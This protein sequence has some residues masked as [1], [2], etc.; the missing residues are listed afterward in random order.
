MTP[1]VVEP[2]QS[3]LDSWLLLA[4]DAGGTSTRATLARAGVD[5]LL[6]PIGFGAAGPGNPLTA[7][8]DQAVE[9]IETAIAEAR[10]AADCQQ[11][12][13]VALL[14]VAGAASGLTHQRLLDWGSQ[15]R[16]AARVTV[17]AD[18]APV[19]AAADPGP[20][21]GIISGT[22]SVVIAR[23]RAGQPSV[24]GGW[25]YLLG[26]EGSG[27]S[28]GREAVRTVLTVGE[29]GGATTQLADALLAHF[30]SPNAALLP[31]LIH[32]LPHP[33]TDLASLARVVV[34]LAGEGDPC[35]DM[36]IA[37]AARDLAEVAARAAKRAGLFGEE[38][39]LALSGGVLTHC[40]TLRERL[41][42]ELIRQ[43]IEVRNA[44]V[45]HDATL[46]GL[47]MAAADHDPRMAWRI[48]PTVSK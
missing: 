43:G 25:G 16:L 14:A 1:V 28:I 36:L 2:D 44:T 32:R 24:A 11:Q 6:N 35:C 40:A 27:Y 8:F 34:D 30:A 7:G 23:S 4:V 45:V 9:A 48:L 5:G 21:L 22:G 13:A 12:V 18:W 46:N 42:D 39:S 29:E 19:L 41:Q 17:V 26:D 38:V 37:N 33:R 3:V 31:G 10:R 15:R 20:A 47:M